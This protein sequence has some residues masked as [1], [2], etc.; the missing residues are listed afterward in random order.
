MPRWCALAVAV[1]I[2][3]QLACTPAIVA[4]SGEVSLVAVFANVLA[5]PLVAPATVAGLAGGLL[6]LVSAPV[7]R[8]P[9]T[10]A[11]W[12]VGLILQVAHVSSSLAGA[13][14]GWRAP[15]WLLIVL[16]PLVFAVLWR[17]ARHPAVVV[18]IALGVGLGMWRPPQVG[19]PPDGW[20]MVA[21]D[22]GQG[23][24]TVVST[25]DGSAML[26]D[27]GPEPVAV[28]RCL[29]R[30]RVD[31]LPVV[32][33]THA[34]ADHIDGWAGA[35]S[36]RDVGTVFVGPTGGP[37]GVPAGEL[38]AGQSFGVGSLAVTVLWPTAGVTMAENDASLVLRVTTQNVRLLLTGDVEPAAQEALLRLRPDLAA[39]VV[40]MPHHGSGRQS[41]RFIAAAGAR[42]ATIS[43]GQDND[44]GHPAAAALRLLRDHDISWWR[45]DTDGDIAVVVRDGRLSVVTRLG[46]H[47]RSLRGC[48]HR[49]R[50]D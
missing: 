10:V 11:G 48:R 17:L 19:W 36:G 39:D 50:A 13:S 20:V 2:A 8:V 31:R 43:A 12:C 9:G 44:Y 29:D 33:I 32:A 45:T 15:W 46:T 25:G 18:G 41:E 16:V 5:G 38:V 34:H 42:V 30:L 26:V 24:A 37:A 7:A 22:V 14:L 49:W 27:V 35:V 21:C 4:I 40:K 28:D 3:A 47:R 6:D 23:D 1:P